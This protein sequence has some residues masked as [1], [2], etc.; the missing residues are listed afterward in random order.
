MEIDFKL[1]GVSAKSRGI[2]LQ[3]PIEFEEVQLNVTS[4]SVAGVNG[5]LH[6]TDGT[7]KERRATASCYC[8]DANDT[9]EQM[10]TITQFLFGSSPSYR[11]LSTDDI[12]YWEALV[13]SAAGLSRRTPKLN[14]FNITFTCKPFQYLFE[15]A[16]F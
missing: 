12:Y 1:D 9:D 5:E 4:V 16:V 10:R 13:L 15:G 2:L 14:T 3:K 7:Y 8:L 11:K 6:I